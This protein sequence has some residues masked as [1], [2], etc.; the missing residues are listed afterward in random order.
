MIGSPH[1]IFIKHNK[2]GVEEQI[3]NILP[4][5]WWLQSVYYQPTLASFSKRQQTI[6]PQPAFNWQIVQKYSQKQT[7]IQP[8]KL[9]FNSSLTQI[10]GKPYTTR[11]NFQYT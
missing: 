7:S 6:S 8:I 9:N 4:S 11:E 3:N 2:R 10:G 5:K 1:I